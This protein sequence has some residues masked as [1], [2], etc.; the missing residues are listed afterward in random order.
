M[1]M[2]PGSRGSDGVRVFGAAAIEALLPVADC[3]DSL[4]AAFREPAGLKSFVGGVAAPEGK[5]HIKAALGAAGRAVFAAKINANFPGNPNTRGLPTIQGVLALFDAADG[6]V[7]A[8]MDSMSITAIR[9]AAAT[10][11][12]ARYLSRPDASAAAIVGCG[13]QAPAQL[14]AVCAVR[15]IRRVQLFDLDRGAAERLVAR[16]RQSQELDAVAVDT[17]DAATQGADIIVTSTP[18]RRPFLRRSHVKPGMFVAAVGADNPDK[19]E[20]DPEVLA[21]SLVVVDDLEQCA[22]MGDLHHALVAGV[23]DRS[24]VAGTLSDVL[25]DPGSFA[26][27]AD[28]SVVF[29]STGIPLE[30]VAAAARVLER[31]QQVDSGQAISLR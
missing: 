2:R 12:A 7:L 28:R 6:R 18:S 25:A 4:D 23:V 21:A 1:K 27:K 14:R 5:F 29:D 3:I 19:H 24:H 31:G 15:P 8:I 22:T 17:L 9:T 26:W 13:A 16:I 11:L 10:G 20:I 30:D